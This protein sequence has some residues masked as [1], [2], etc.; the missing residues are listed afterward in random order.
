MNHGYTVFTRADLDGDGSVYYYNGSGD[1]LYSFGD[2]HRV[3]MT[4]MPSLGYRWQQRVHPLC[5]RT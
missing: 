4:S 3:G 5:F 2:Y 1:E